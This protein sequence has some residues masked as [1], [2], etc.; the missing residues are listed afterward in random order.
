[1]RYTILLLSMIMVLACQAQAP[2]DR[3]T[4]EDAAFDKMVSRLLSY[5]VPLK[6]VTDFSDGDVSQY[7]V[8]DARERAEYNVSHIKGARYI[9]YDNFDIKKLRGT[10]KSQPI[11]VYCSVGY[12][13][14]KIGEKL[15]KAGYSRVYNLYGSLF[16]WVNHGL[17]IVNNTGKKQQKIHTYNQRWSKWVLNKTYQKIW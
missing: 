2:A 6:G 9:G 15:Q 1:M 14:E 10:P 12:R 5:T 3:P 16:E 17:P 13:S 8:L 11:L 4:C 7:L